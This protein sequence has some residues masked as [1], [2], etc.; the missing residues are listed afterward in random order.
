MHEPDAP[1]QR[2]SAHSDSESFL[3]INRIAM[4]GI[5]YSIIS[6]IFLVENLVLRRARQHECVLVIR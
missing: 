5:V 1:S 2:S 6:C 3:M 4:Y